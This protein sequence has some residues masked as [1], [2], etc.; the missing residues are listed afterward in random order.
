MNNKFKVRGFLVSIAGIMT[1]LKDAFQNRKARFEYL[2]INYV[3]LNCTK[4]Y[5]FR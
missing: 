4:Y 1:F 3:K 5:I 2:T